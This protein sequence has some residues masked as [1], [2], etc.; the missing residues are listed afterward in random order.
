MWF[1]IR[2]EVRFRYFV[3]TSSLVANNKSAQ[4]SSAV[5]VGLSSAEVAERLAQFG[6]NDPT[7]VKRGAA[8]GELIT[9]LLNPLVVILLVASLVSLVLGDATD[10]VVILVIVFLGISINFTQT[11]RS[12]R[13]IQKL[14]EN[15]T[16]TATALR[17]GI[18]QEVKR[19]EVVVV[20][21]FD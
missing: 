5:P 13:A 17:D 8:I 3:M 15:V 20:V 10:S 12:Q 19:H 21:Q 14:R 18:W 2:D 11:Y 7:P 16:P 1:S 6:S 9:L 4:I